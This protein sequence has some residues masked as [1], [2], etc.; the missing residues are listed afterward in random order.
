MQ[1]K[2]IF[3]ASSAELK[4]DRDQFEIAVNRKNKEWIRQGIF[5]ELVVWEDFLDA[6][7]RTRLQD[8]YN[9]VIRQCDI[10]VMLFWTKVGQ[11]TEEEFA[12]A[13]GQFKAANKPF[14]FTYLKTAPA[15]S[16]DAS[17]TAF[18]N[19]LDTMG[20]FVTR[21]ENIDFLKYHFNHQLE[22]L[23]ANGFIELKWDKHELLAGG[24]VNYTAV[25][26][27][28]V[29]HGTQAKLEDSGGY[30]GSNVSAGRDV[31]GRDIN[32]K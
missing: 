22:K 26:N 15:V 25:V 12:T 3:L 32:N 18:K 23:A 17:L 7:S 1:I 11:F 9:K 24:D 28:N 31:A 14:V 10:F 13:A 2:K 29:N 30:F 4:A 21:Y 5:L 27:T 16:I 6:L 19:K 20:H 8:E